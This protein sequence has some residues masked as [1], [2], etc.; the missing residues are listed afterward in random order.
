MTR[1][2]PD[3]LPYLPVPH[4]TYDRTTIK[5]G[6]VH[7]GIGAFHRAHQ[8]AYTEAVLNREGGDWGI[9]GC[10]LRSDAVQRQLAPQDGLYTLVERG[11]NARPQIIGAVQQVLVG[12]ENTSAIVA[13][14]ALP[15]VKIY[16]LTITEKGYCHH[17]ATGT[18]NFKHPDIQADINNPLNPKSAPGVIVAG[19]RARLRHQLPPVSVVSCDNLPNNGE[20]TRAVVVALAEILDPELAE[21]IKAEVSFPGTMVDRIVPATT[22]EDIAWLES[23]YD[24][25]DEGLVV[26]EPFSQWVI[27]D[28]FCNDRPAWE[29]AGALLVEDV[30]QY[31][32]M[33]LR[34]LNGSHSLMAYSGYL[35]GYTT[36]YQVIQDPQFQ[37]LVS[38]FMAKAATTFDAPKNFDLATYQQQLLQRFAN[39]GLQHKTWQIAMDGSQK[40]PQ[41]WLN[42]LRALIARGEDTRLFAFALATWMRF[43]DGTDEKGDAIIVS[44]PMAATL[45][46]I[47]RRH[48]GNPAQQVQAFFAL[49]AIFGTDLK[50]N[51]ELMQ[52]T[53]RELERIQTRGVRGALEE[54]LAAALP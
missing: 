49:E 14:M 3:L 8:A 19:L 24:Y 23:H 29:H 28:N 10:S 26:A 18:L 32:M 20:V 41:R 30:A 47:T 7:L 46:D 50:D 6:I 17:P 12:A 38:R 45:M 52:Q 21:W 25:R 44:D 43:L 34:L 4:P 11:S 39:P 36:I 9:I 42:S 5:P 40:I 16:S 33:K 27:E 51:T 13:A 1:L 54:L 53:E 2:N 22:A 31:E 15:T 37:E 35:A 48:E